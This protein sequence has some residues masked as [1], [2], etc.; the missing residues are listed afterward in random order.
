MTAASKL[1]RDLSNNAV[2]LRSGDTRGAKPRML[3]DDEI[4]VLKKRRDGFRDQM[5]EARKQR[6]SARVNAHTAEQSD[7]VIAASADQQQRDRNGEC[8]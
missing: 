6:I 4:E 7:R 1:S 3:T 2:Q 8:G 5:D